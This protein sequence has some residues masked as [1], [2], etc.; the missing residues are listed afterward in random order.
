M[1]AKSLTSSSYGQRALGKICSTPLTTFAPN[2]A[3]EALQWRLSRRDLAE[4]SH[5]FGLDRPLAIQRAAVDFETPHRRAAAR[6]DPPGTGLDAGAR[7]GRPRRF[8]DAFARCRTALT[9]SAIRARS[10]SAIAPQDVHLQLAGG[11]GRSMPSFS[12]TNAMPKALSSSSSVINGGMSDKPRSRTQKGR[13]T[14]ALSLTPHTL[15]WTCPRD[16]P[17][18]S[19]NRCCCSAPIIS[20]P[21]DRGGRTS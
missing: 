16:L 11:R 2:R 17:R 13:L 3:S 19:S 6:T 15:F 8:P 12:D 18:S 5:V 9:R 1:E 7:L 14:F 21:M 20:R 10:N 4:S